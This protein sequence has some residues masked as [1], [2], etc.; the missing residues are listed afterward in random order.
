M[1]SP[2]ARLLLKF[3]PGGIEDADQIGQT[4]LHLLSF[5]Q[6]VG[7]VE[8]GNVNHTLEVVGFGK[9]RDNLV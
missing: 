1:S 5:A 6:L 3:R 9:P 7:I 4:V 2:S 8:V